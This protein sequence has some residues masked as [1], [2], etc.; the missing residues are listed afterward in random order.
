MIPPLPGPTLELR[1]TPLSVVAENLLLLRSVEYR[2]ALHRVFSVLKMRFSDHERAIYEYVIDPGEGIRI[3]GPAPLGEGLLTGISS[4]AA[5]TVNDN[6]IEDHQYTGCTKADAK[7][8]G[9]TYYVSTGILLLSVDQA[10]VD[11]KNNTYRNNDVNLY[12]GSN[13]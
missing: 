11:T 7:A 13:Q 2:G 1:N 9:C 4:G 8:T 10:L 5:A 6:F 12:N 3:T